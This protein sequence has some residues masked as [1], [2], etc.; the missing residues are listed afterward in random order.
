MK[1]FFLLGISLMFIH[2]N[3]FSQE[4]KIEKSFFIP[5]GI[6]IGQIGPSLKDMTVPGRGD[7]DLPWGVSGIGTDGLGNIILL[8]NI[9]KKLLVFTSTGK[10][11]E[12]IQGI[13]GIFDNGYPFGII[14]ESEEIILI[15]NKYSI[16][17]FD[18]QTKELLSYLNV[19]SYSESYRRF[20]YYTI[21]NKT[22]FYWNRQLLWCIPDIL[23]PN[24]K[25][26]E[27]QSDHEILKKNGIEVRNG[28][29]YLPNGEL[30]FKNFSIYQLINIPEDVN[31]GI[32]GEFLGSWKGIN[33]WINNK[34]DI[35]LGPIGKTTQRKR[36]VDEKYLDFPVNIFYSLSSDGFVYFTVFSLTEGGTIVNRLD[37][38]PF[39]DQKNKL[40]ETN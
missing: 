34:T 22:A 13:G 23:K 6:G 26:V 36:V 8:D 5:S 31:K 40:E 24:S 11:V 19:R 25:P 29:Y 3:C 7:T 14:S 9:N 16:S 17:T 33:V 32:D 27:L 38:R 37:L 35:I 28:V 2:F 1:R 30:L 4:W 39:L 18:I 20:L 10:L 15:H 21:F 12:E